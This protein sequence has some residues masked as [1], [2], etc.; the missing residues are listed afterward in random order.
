MNIPHERRLEISQL[1]VNRAREVARLRREQREGA[2]CEVMRAALALRLP[3]A[4]DSLGICGWR[5]IAGG[6][7]RW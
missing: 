2:V 3:G 1:G 6:R 4:A 7:G 5:A